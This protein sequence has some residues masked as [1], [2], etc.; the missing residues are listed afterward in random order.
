[1]TGFGPVF[2]LFVSGVLLDLDLSSVKG[3]V[4]EIQPLCSRRIKTELRHFEMLT[5]LF[6]EIKKEKISIHCTTFF[7][8]VH[9]SSNMN[10]CILHNNT[11]NH[12]KPYQT[13][14]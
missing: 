7:N 5:T 3:E 13:I 6:Q 2:K 1:M 11:N 9:I 14:C 12:H 4:V 8:H 10:F